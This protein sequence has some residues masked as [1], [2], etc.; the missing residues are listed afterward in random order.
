[1]AREKPTNKK[2]T[3]VIEANLAALAIAKPPF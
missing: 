3:A 1:L 2:I